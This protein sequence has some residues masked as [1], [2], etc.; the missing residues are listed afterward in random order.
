MAAAAVSLCLGACPEMSFN[1]DVAQY[2]DYATNDARVLSVD[3][4]SYPSDSD[5]VVCLPSDSALTLSIKLRNINKYNVNPVVTFT[6]STASSERSSTN[7]VTI[8]QDDDTNM[9]LALSREF[10]TA[11]DKSGDVSFYISMSEDNGRTFPTSNTYKVRVNTPPPQIPQAV[12][13]Y[14]LTTQKYILCF[15]MPTIAS[16]RVTV[17]QD[18]KTLRI[19]DSD[20]DKTTDFSISLGSDG[21]FTLPSEFTTAAPA[22]LTAIDGEGVFT[23][24]ANAFYMQSDVT[25][26]NAVG[27]LYDITILDSG[28]LSSTCQA[29]SGPKAATYTITYDANGAESGSVPVDSAR[30]IVNAAITM[31]GNTG[32]LVKS[33]YRF[34]GWARSATASAAEYSAGDTFSMTSGNVTF[35]AV[36]TKLYYITYEGNGNSGGT[37]PATGSYI[38][39]ETVT[40]PGNTG[41]LTKDSCVFKGWSTSSSATSPSYT[42]GSTF[43]MGGSNMTLYAVWSGTGS[44]T[45][46]LPEYSDIGDIVTSNSGTT[47][48]FTVATGYSSYAWY[49][50]GA[51]IS[52]ATGNSYSRDMSTLADGTHSIVIIANGN[53]SASIQITV[54]EGTVQ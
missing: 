50:D 26:D 22:E 43:L 30:H 33:G 39:G 29:A 36:W 13:E 40:V 45:V 44:I 15:N 21:T 37:V 11:M 5:S 48:T 41:A 28:G 19:Y 53:R 7:G 20:N 18:I 17:Q 9:S 35:Y 38:E 12:I 42:E 31:P 49:L 46:T 27:Q 3:L 51:V 54:V 10:L 16:D 1:T 23:P 14:N 6:D 2:L 8:T 52:G 4:S 24:T 34:M 47:Y 25:L 32:S